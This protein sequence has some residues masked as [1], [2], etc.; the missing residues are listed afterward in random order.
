MANQRDT[1]PRSSV[2]GWKGIITV[3]IFDKQNFVQDADIREQ[4]GVYCEYELCSRYICFY[5]ETRHG[6][7]TFGANCH[8]T[9]M[10][11]TIEAKIKAMPNRRGLAMVEYTEEA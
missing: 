4:A 8:T 2:K 11:T 3:A 10:A 1:G 5:K 6:L 7:K 9:R